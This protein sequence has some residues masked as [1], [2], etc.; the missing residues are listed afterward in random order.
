MARCEIASL[1]WGVLTDD[2]GNAMAARGVT[3]AGFGPSGKVWSD[4]QVG[5]GTEL[6]SIQTRADGTIP[7]YI[8]EGGYNV[9]VAGV[10]QYVDVV[11]GAR[12]AKG[13]TRIDIP[14]PV[15]VM[16]PTAGSAVLQCRDAAGKVQLFVR[17]PNGT[18][19]ILAT[20]GTVA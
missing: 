16:T 1:S 20:E 7:G 15:G 10:T 8:D 6:T 14:S 4:P 17:F 2:N 5:V 3:I 9:T 19:T 13:A 11:A 18:E 12:Q